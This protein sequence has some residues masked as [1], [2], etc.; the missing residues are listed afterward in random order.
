[1]RALPHLAAALLASAL[2]SACH[3]TQPLVADASYRDM[4]ASAPSWEYSETAKSKYVIVGSQTFAM[5]SGCQF[6]QRYAVRTNADFNASMNLLK[7]RSA[8]MGANWITVAS[9]SEIDLL[10]QPGYRHRVPITWREGTIPRN[11]RYLTELVGDLYDCPCGVT[12]CAPHS[13]N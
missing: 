12:A 6:L 2:L 1:M 10:E 13:N 5:A 11:N 9:H 3:T 4:T 7:N 8:L